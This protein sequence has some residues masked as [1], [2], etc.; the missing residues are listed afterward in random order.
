MDLGKLVEEAI[1]EAI[2]EGAFDN[3]AGAGKPFGA[4]EDSSGENW[5]GFHILKSNGFLPEWLELRKQIANRRDDVLEALDAWRAAVV[6]YGDAG[7][8]LAREAHGEYVRQATAVNALIDLH[9][10]RCPSIHLE[11]VR[12]REDARIS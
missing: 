7:H 2:D 11:I 5:M 12:F 9:N 4:L 6:R 1:R 10:L 3:L 8:I